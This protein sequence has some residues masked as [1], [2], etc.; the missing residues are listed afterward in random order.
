MTEMI[1][2]R[3]GSAELV[4]APQTGGAVVSWTRGADPIFRRPNVNP[5]GARDLAS[6]PLVP[7]SNRV[8]N[9]RFSFAG[10]DYALPDLMMGWAIHGAG[11][12]GD[13]DDQ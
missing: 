3:D 5:T 12:A 6:Y 10:T 7:Y 1:A 9:R 11:W 8:A 4:L 2:L 13:G